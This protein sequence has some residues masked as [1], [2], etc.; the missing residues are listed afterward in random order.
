[1]LSDDFESIKE[2]NDWHSSAAAQL[3]LQ[4]AND[5]T[6][7]VCL[8]LFKHSISNEEEQDSSPAET[9]DSLQFARAKDE[10]EV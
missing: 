10:E 1:M 2:W 3:L 6:W 9:K 4:Y 7:V 8:V 5:K